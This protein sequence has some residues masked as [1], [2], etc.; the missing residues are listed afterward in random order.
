V[1]SDIAPKA[2]TLGWL[3]SSTPDKFWV[4]EKPLTR[5]VV[6]LITKGVPVHQNVFT[7]F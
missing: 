4:K 2:T 1:S 3:L 5:F 6:Y 7:G